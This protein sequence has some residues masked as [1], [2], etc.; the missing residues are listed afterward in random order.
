MKSQNKIYLVK[1]LNTK[2]F[3]TVFRFKF[4]QETFRTYKIKTELTYYYYI[5]W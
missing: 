5:K 1:T 4:T 3:F 2:N